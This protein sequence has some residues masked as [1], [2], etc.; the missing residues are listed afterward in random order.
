[1]IIKKDPS[2]IQS[3]LE[4][5]SNLGGGHAE[6]VCIPE[7][8]EEAATFIKEANSNNLPVTISG[9]GTGTS[10]GRVPFGGVVLSMEKLNKIKDALGNKIT[11]EAGV[12]IKDLKAFADKKGLFYTYDPTEQS[13][14]IG[15]TIATNASGARSFKYGSTRKSVSALTVLLADG[16]IFEINRG[17]IKS[18]DGIL[19]FKVNT[20]AYKI[21]V[22]HYKMS[23]TKNSAGYYAKKGMDLIDLFIGQEGTLG[24]ILQVTLELIPK[25]DDIL[26]CFAFFKRESEAIDF[27]MKAR[28]HSTK[29]PSK[30]SAS[31][32]ALS[33]EYFDKYTLDLIRKKSGNVP[34]D[35][36]ACVFFE[37]EVSK[38]TE[39]R[40]ISGWE[41]LIKECGSSLNDTW[42]AMNEKER[43]NLLDIRH[44]LGESMNEMTKAN[45]F[46]KVT[47]DL[48]VPADR[49]IKMM[50]YYNLVLENLGIQYFLFGHI[51]DSHIHMNLMPKSEKEFAESKKA[52]MYFIKKSVEFGG[53]V[54]AEHGI[55]KLRR[56]YLKILYGEKGVKEML[57]VKKI[58][59]PNL[60]L[61]RGN[62]FNVEGQSLAP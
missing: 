38:R 7:N 17:A 18:K 51:G 55:G 11:C 21:P 25:P 14:F 36:G 27:A 48:A 2:I 58:L 3:Y 61:G 41:V 12:L 52:A 22:P 16:S 30:K 60:I 28:E 42:V 32:D 13:A 50:E 26:C 9:G 10:G 4:D 53:T 23:K 34:K 31:I 57:E 8:F 29:K 5:S 1:V 33:I 43:Q 39:E 19:K 59:D 24:C 40:I 15:G 35:S 49:L 47:T 20:K 62:I 46:S 56:E 44:S 54:S 37:Q 6:E 45:K